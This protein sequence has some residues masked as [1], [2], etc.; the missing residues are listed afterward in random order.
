MHPLGSKYF[1]INISL[2]KSTAAIYCPLACGEKPSKLIP[3]AKKR[4]SQ[5]KIGVFPGHPHET[6][7]IRRTTLFPNSFNWC[8]QVI[9]DWILTPKKQ[10]YVPWISTK[11]QRRRTSARLW[12]WKLS[13]GIA[14]DGLMSWGLVP[15]VTNHRGFHGF[16][17]IGTK[18]DLSHSLWVMTVVAFD[19]GICRCVCVCDGLLECWRMLTLESLEQIACFRALFL[20]FSQCLGMA[21]RKS[22]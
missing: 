7:G 22:K 21:R 12:L 4:L 8:M 13:R 10:F 14:G 16:L 5:S 3:P 17:L 20:D 1:K 15:N 9:L 11:W 18:G 6:I 19:S 2:G